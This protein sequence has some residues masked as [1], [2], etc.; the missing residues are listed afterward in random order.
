MSYLAQLSN[1]DNV[2]YGGSAYKAALP[3]NRWRIGG[4]LALDTGPHRVFLDMR[5]GHGSDVSREV[6]AVVGYSYRF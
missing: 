3:G 1:D 2:S 6:S 5:Y 4:G